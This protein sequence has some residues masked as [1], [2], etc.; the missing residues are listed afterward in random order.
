MQFR[1]IFHLLKALTK[2]NKILLTSAALSLSTNLQKRLHSVYRWSV[3]V[4]E[5]SYFYGP[6]CKNSYYMRNNSLR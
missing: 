5:D 1:V 3:E 6:S 4:Y 2:R